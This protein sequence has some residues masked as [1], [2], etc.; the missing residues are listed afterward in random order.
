VQDSLSDQYSI[1]AGW[2]SVIIAG[3][4]ALITFWQMMEARKIRLESG[5]PALSLMPRRWIAGGPFLMLFLVNNGGLARNVEI[6]LTYAEERRS[7]YIM[8]LAENDKLRIVE[9]SSELSKKGGKLLVHVNYKD[10][11]GKK[12]QDDMEVDFD[13]L[14]QGNFPYVTNR[15]DELSES[16]YDIGQKL[17]NR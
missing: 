11:Y 17:R 1:D 9:D 4:L 16:L 10:A 7:M 15:L 3:V 13:K 8:S 12:H 14:K 6:E 5:R 2:A